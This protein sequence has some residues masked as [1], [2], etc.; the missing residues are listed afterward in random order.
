[1][2]EP[3]EGLAVA[4]PVDLVELERFDRLQRGFPAMYRRIFSDPKA[5]RTV[6]VV[7]SMSLDTQELAKIE[8]VLHYEERMLCL[9]M[10]LK[11]PRTEVIYVT[12]MPI[13][14]SIVDYYLHLLPGVPAAHARSRLQMVACHDSSL[15]P[16][17]QK[18][19]ERPDVIESVRSAIKFP[20]AAHMT[21]FN[22]TSLERTLAVRL[23]R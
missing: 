2:I 18:I 21:C 20:E 7:P 15:T 5:P 22:S 1:M 8:G 19:L 6:I 23:A 4:P 17:T 9:L 13:D 10:L 12:S 3:L 11:L 16:L 14:P